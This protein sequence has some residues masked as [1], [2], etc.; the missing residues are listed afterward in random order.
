MPLE[1]GSRLVPVDTPTLTPYEPDWNTALN[2]CLALR[3]GLGLARQD[4]KFRQFDLISQKN[5]LL[6][7]LRFTSTMA[8]NGLGSTLDGSKSSVLPPN[9]LNPNAV[10]V[11]ANAFR[12]LAT[13][14]PHRY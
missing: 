7:D 11:P 3:P 2:E 13:G 1:D 8:P 6:P 12:T 4:L 5:L 14:F 10:P 9:A